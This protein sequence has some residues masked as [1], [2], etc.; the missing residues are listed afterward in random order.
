MNYTSRAFASLALLGLA[1]GLLARSQKAEDLVDRVEG[2]RIASRMHCDGATNPQEEVALETQ[3]S[4]GGLER[5]FHLDV[6]ESRYCKHVDLYFVCLKRG[7][8]RWKHLWAADSQAPQPSRR[9]WIDSCTAHQAETAP[10]YILSGWYR[11]AGDKKAA[12]KQAAVKKVSDS[13]EVYEFSDP[14]G[15]TARVAVGRK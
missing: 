11:E 14:Q 1:A 4:P 6:F 5:A 9:Y 10:E 2:V 15:G 3:F 7:R 8:D 13:P 12:W